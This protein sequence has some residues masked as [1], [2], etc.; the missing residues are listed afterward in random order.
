MTAALALSYL[1]G[2]WMMGILWGEV[3]RV[4]TRLWVEWMT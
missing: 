2:S 1:V 4:I 3:W